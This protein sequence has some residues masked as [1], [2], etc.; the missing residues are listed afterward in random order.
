MYEQI[1]KTREIIYGNSNGEL[2][3][4]PKDLALELVQIYSAL[5]ASKT[6]SEFKANVPVHVYEEVIKGMK[7]D[8]DPETVPQS[9]DTFDPH[10][11]PAYEDGDW[12]IWP[13]QEMLEWMPKDIQQQFGTVETS[14]TSG[15][16]LVLYPEKTHEIVEALEKQGYR[17]F[18]DV[19]L[20]ESASGKK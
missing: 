5:S 12:P 7:D 13:L 18:E 19:S 2:V 8:E 16:C 9:E 14:A 3:F 10:S 17:C 11:I 1:G 6:W 4:M 15:S 20:I